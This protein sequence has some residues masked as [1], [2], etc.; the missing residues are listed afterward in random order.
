MAE[1]HSVFSEEALECAD[2]VRE[3]VHELVWVHG[4][5][6]PAETLSI[7]EGRVGASENSG[8]FGEEDGFVHDH[9]VSVGWTTIHV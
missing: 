7:G 2:L 3:T 1:L 4:H 8:F 6:A 5:L 9:E